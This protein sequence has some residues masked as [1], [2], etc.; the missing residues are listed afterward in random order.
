[1]FGKIN[2]KQDISN[3]NVPRLAPNFK[4]VC[5]QC[6]NEELSEESLFLLIND[7]YNEK[8]K[9]KL[10]QYLNIYKDKLYTKY[11]VI[12]NKYYD[13]IIKYKI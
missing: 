1:M 2:N 10:E 7:T 13:D 4:F 11:L 5:F 12:V 6:K 3:K 8:N 9:I